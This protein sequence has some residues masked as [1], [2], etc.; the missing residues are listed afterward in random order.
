MLDLDPIGSFN[1]IRDN[2]ILYV[3]TAFGTRFPSIEE[4][5]ERL[6]NQTGVLCQEL[7][8]EPLPRYKS[9]GKTMQQIENTALPGLTQEE[10]TSFK[11]LALCG[12][13]NEEIQLHLHQTE[14]LRKA[15]MGKNC[16]VTAGTGSGKTESFL[17]PL[18]ASLAKESLKWEKP[19]EKHL[20]SD[21]WWKNEQWQAMCLNNKRLSRSYR[22]SQ[23]SH[24]KR[25]PALRA[26]ILYPMNALVED[27]MT[28]LRKALD[29]GK[30]SNWFEAKRNGN[31]IY[32]GRYNSNTPV[33]GHEFKPPK[34]GTQTPD[35]GRIEKLMKILSEIDQS[36]RQAAK[37]AKKGGKDELIYFFP[38]LTGAEMRSRWDMQDTPPDILITN[39]SM[40]GIMMMRE[41]ENSIFQKTKDWLAE[42]ESHVF[43]MI[44]DE[45]HMYRGT[46]GAEVAYLL[47]LFL[48]RIGLFPN[49]P[50]LRILGSSASLE[51]DDPD[52]LKFLQDFFGANQES[53]EII[54]G[55]LAPVPAVKGDEYLPTAPFI[56][57]GDKAPECSNED[58][59]Q[60][61]KS[62]GYNEPESEGRIALKEQLESNSLA[63]GSRMLNACHLKGQMR[64]VSLLEF[65]KKIFDPALETES[66]LKAARGLLLARAICNSNGE[67][68]SLPAFRLHIFFRNIEGLWAST[69]PLENSGDR[70]VGEL[71][72]N[73]KIIS[74]NG[75]RI[76]EL[77]YCE[78]CGVVYLGGNRLALE[79]N[80]FE[81][82][83]SDPDLDG[84]PD[85]QAARFLEQRTYD[86]YAI[87]WPEGKL[88]IHEDA[89]KR[90]KQPARSS[91]DS[92]HANWRPAC[93][94]ISTG[95]VVL[96]H[97]KYSFDPEN[98]VKG[99]LFTIDEVDENWINFKALPSICAQCGINYSRRI[100]R[101]S[102]VRGFRTG[103]TKVSQILTKELFYQLPEIS[104]HKLVVFSDSRE[105]A[106]QISNGV[107]R[108]HY[109]DLMREAVIDEIRMIVLG[110]QQL[111]DDLTNKHKPVHPLALHYSER[112]PDEYNSIKEDIETSVTNPAGLPAKFKREIEE[113][114]QRLEKMREIG[115]TRIINVNH[116]LPPAHDLSECGPLIK[117]LIS[118]GTN[119][120]GNDILYQEFFWD[121]KYRY[122]TELFDFGALKWRGNLPQSAE[123]AKG[124]IHNKV[125][126][127]LCDLFFS[128]LYF[129][130]ESSGLGYSKLNI[131]DETLNLLSS[132]T[133]VDKHSFEQICDSVIRILGDLY[134][135]RLPEPEYPLIDWIDYSDSRALLKNYI[136]KIS[137]IYN[138]GELQ[139]GAAVFNA[140]NECEHHGAI[141]NT[142]LLKIKLAVDSDPVWICSNCRRPH[143]HPSAGVCTNCKTLLPK[144]PN[145]RC[146]ELWLR[147]YLATH[148]ANLRSP[149][150][151]HCEELTAQ[152]DDQFE[153]Q[154]HFRGVIIDLPNQERRF[155]KIVDEIDVLSVTTTM[156]VGVDIGNLQ[157]V[158]LA[159][160]PPMRF[161]YQ[162]RVGRA[163]RRG[164]AFSVALTLCRGRSH[165][166][167]YFNVPERITGDP[168]PTPF[169]TMNQRLI[170]KR[171]IVKEFL[172]RAFWAAGARWWNGPDT[173]DSHGE[174]GKTEDWPVYKDAVVN[175]L[176][177][178]SS[179]PQI[180]QAILG[181]IN[182]QENGEWLK[183]AGEALPDMIENAIYNQEIT[184]DGIAERLAEAGI[185][186]M[187]G[188]PSRVR[189]LYHGQKI[190]GGL[191]SGT[192]EPP[193]VD[194]DIEIAI[195]EFAPGSEKTKDKAIHTAIGFT[196]PLI[197][198]HSIWTAV[199]SD[200]PLS[201][202]Y[203]MA[204]CRSCGH[205]RTSINQV[206]YSEC[207]YCGQPENKNISE[208]YFRTFK[209]AIPVAFRTDLSP[210][211][212]RKDDAEIVAFGMPSSIAE[213]SDVLY[214]KKTNTN[215]E[216]RLSNECTVWRINDRYGKFFKGRL[217]TTQKFPKAGHG[218]GSTSPLSNQWINEEY[219]PLVSN[220]NPE[221]GLEEIALASRK[222][223]DL[224]RIRHSTL[225]LSINVDPDISTRL[226]FGA[227]KG[228]LYSASFIITRTAAELLDID[229]DEI[230]I[231]GFRRTQQG[232]AYFPEIVLS[233]RLPN[234]SGLVRWI[235]EKWHTILERILSPQSA[236][237]SFPSALIAGKHKAGKDACD[238]ACYDCLKVY[239]N[240]SYHGLLDWRLGLAF[241]RLFQ[242]GNYQI[243]VD[244]DF[245]TPELE[246][247]PGFAI[248]LRDNFISYFGYERASFGSL[249]GFTAD[250]N[251]VIIIHPLWHYTNNP[252][253]ILADAVAEADIMD[254]H[255]L[256]TFNLLRRPGW[257][258]NH[259]GKQ[260]NN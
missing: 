116:L 9:S 196:Q 67:S 218:I 251:A 28:R 224:L 68:S 125:I 216:T 12:L 149:L 92:A 7:W 213:T 184:A 128:R 192:N 133:A 25:S 132:E 226:V 59:L 31:R 245:S 222:T 230:E 119:P 206:D 105:D 81:L 162:Q 23:R 118:T 53:F 156:E 8:I 171:L 17:L 62:L 180:L 10:Q 242:N 204:R 56:K 211:R 126:E 205:T 58:F 159:N 151:L 37:E 101:K 140:L 113:A 14:M 143:L 154:R 160:M 61:A 239:R 21:D 164:Q 249:P 228:A 15:L 96:T 197:K 52:S 130:L 75:S 259:L 94:Y 135:Y 210:G 55:E 71:Y 158:M 112:Y 255:F 38:K 241:I 80:E 115:T 40:L 194:R 201:A 173:P 11:E 87:F 124:R 99:Y 2:F 102:P 155:T 30:A 47:R 136:R 3:K 107:E 175:W 146:A 153:R 84:L 137:E 27:Q 54:T 195:T 76:L 78:H 185:L 42:D 166:E 108:N 90:W 250:N 221:T 188:M 182:S 83:P 168:P 247:W 86:E 178:N 134:R 57:L 35:R 200:S 109:N 236:S 150:R 187:F 114:K 91:N 217:V 4:E 129:S 49:H 148:S 163:G 110:K 89:A 69:K 220:D 252:Q 33:P 74:N 48:N 233:D 207:P 29:S 147:N 131:V 6:L 246:N 199:S 183:F 223:T 203:F 227:I 24:E 152:T 22:V 98:W 176:Q 229:P 18:F 161:N 235:D 186:P 123:S 36:A 141:I 138:I 95:R 157:A 238:S 145:S 214:E 120:A 79:N 20:H 16:I 253:G 177:Q 39:F 191:P 244:G 189:L 50:Q 32:F 144:E 190:H 73:P 66:R 202:R 117:K 234:G 232:D 174:F 111:L 139:L 170:A 142:R 208:S 41:A 127:A 72:L 212:D 179:R 77:L 169:L 209:I 44:V 26:L 106:A 231:C 46:A 100:V 103:F 88:S 13:F 256:D 97:E 215:T 45:L 219:I 237:G 258:H 1:K 122:W 193:S 82:L 104:G 243:G 248:Q 225:P 85:K 43:H 260:S 64:A 172:R 121:N 167:H 165:D 198:Q 181:E 19:G 240:M 257:C 5:R 254:V 65:S 34:N 70:P 93:L 60:A 51:A 63:A